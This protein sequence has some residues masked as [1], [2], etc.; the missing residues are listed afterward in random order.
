MNTSMSQ[1]IETKIEVAITKLAALEEQ[2]RKSEERMEHRFTKLEEKIDNQYVLKIEYLTELKSLL[3]RV[4]SLEADKR[5]AVR[6]GIGAL[7]THAIAYFFAFR[8]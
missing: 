7:I 4:D 1:S 8:Q 6:L 3:A 5:W 2:G